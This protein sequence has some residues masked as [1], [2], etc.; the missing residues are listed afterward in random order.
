[1]NYFKNRIDKVVIIL[2]SQLKNRQLVTFAEKF[3]EI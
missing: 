2:D 1:M 3:K